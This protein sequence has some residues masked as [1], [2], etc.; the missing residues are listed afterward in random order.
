MFP[1]DLFHGWGA[2]DTVEHLLLGQVAWWV[3]PGAR[4][5]GNYLQLLREDCFPVFVADN[6]EADS[7]INFTEQLLE[8]GSF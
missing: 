8:P 1:L 5:L 4:D 3:C 7:S 6:N 2:T